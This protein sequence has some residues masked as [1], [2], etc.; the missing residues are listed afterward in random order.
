VGI[1]A[2]Y[3]SIT[4]A[5][6]WGALPR[7]PYAATLLRTTEA[8]QKEGMPKYVVTGLVLRDGDPNTAAFAIPLI[9]RAT[10][11]VI[12]E[13]NAKSPG[14]IRT[15]GFFE[16]ELTFPGATVKDVAGVLAASIAR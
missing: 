13:V 4:R 2:L 11:T 9:I 5:E 15:I 12:D 3:L 16:H 10:R 14:T 1:D 6:Q 8:D 7:P